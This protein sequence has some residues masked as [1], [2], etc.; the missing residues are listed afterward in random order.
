[1][2]APRLAR[3]WSRFRRA[4][5]HLG[6]I[7]A[8]CRLGEPFRRYTRAWETRSLAFVSQPSVRL[9]RFLAL[10]LSG[11]PQRQPVG[12]LGPPA[13]LE[14]C[15]QIGL[16]VA[17]RCSRF[18]FGPCAGLSGGAA[19][20][21]AAIGAAVGLGGVV[22]LVLSGSRTAATSPRAWLPSSSTLIGPGAA[23]ESGRVSS[24]TARAR[25]LTGPTVSARARAPSHAVDRRSHEGGR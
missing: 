14:G 21:G 24:I 8:V 2:T 20:R 22:V 6:G 3:S 7:F 15:F 10:A 5:S 16:T 11:C 9:S 23:A 12:E 1:M 19:W 4:Q 17:V 25:G 13:M 18:P